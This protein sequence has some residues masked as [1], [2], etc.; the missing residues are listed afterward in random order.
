MRHCKS[1]LPVFDA[2]RIGPKCRAGLAQ[3]DFM[4]GHYVVRS[5]PV[6]AI[7]DAIRAFCAPMPQAQQGDDGGYLAGDEAYSTPEFTSFDQ[8]PAAGYAGYLVS[9]PPSTPLTP[10]AS[11][12]G[13]GTIWDAGLGQCT[14]PQDMG[15]K[16]TILPVSKP[17]ARKTGKV[18]FGPKKRG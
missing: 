5:N 6:G 15:S 13:P 7:F 10:S 9:G 4:F 3:T 18:P 12:C 8:A 14:V 11:P 17:A 1:S 2:D 16:A